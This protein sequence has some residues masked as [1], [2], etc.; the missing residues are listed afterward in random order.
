MSTVIVLGLGPG[1]RGTLSV[2]AV[3]RLSRADI[4]VVDASVATASWQSV[5]S[6]KAR[7]EL[8]AQDDDER[9]RAAVIEHA[10]A[11]RV[12]VR[13][14]G[15][16]GWTSSAA[17]R[18]IRGARR[19]G[20]A[21]DVVP[22]IAES[23]A[24]C[25]PWLSSHP[26]FGRRIV[27]TRMRD[28]ASDTAR[29]L[30]DRG[31]EPWVVPTIELRPSPEPERFDGALR[32]LR[33]YQL[34]AFT[35][36]NGVEQTFERLRSMGKDA[37]ELGACAVAA[38]GTATARSLRERGIDADIIAKEFRGEELAKAILERI[39]ELSGRRVLI[40]RAA[41][42]REVLPEMLREA[43]CVVDV[44]P[45][46]ETVAPGPELVAPFR[47]AIA[48]GRVDA[49]LLTSS[50]TVKN[51][52]AMLGQ[53]YAEL[54]SMTVLA[55]IGPITSQTARELGLSIGVEAEQ[56]TIAGLIAALE[57]SFRA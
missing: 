11:G 37:R 13:A 47:E 36:A 41:E 8:V 26:L 49:V 23:A 28:Q 45:A 9:A 27:V 22:G 40:P 57:S 12:V 2:D 43:G 3:D 38:I 54:L 24:A 39:R 35:S 44:V 6:A 14:R 16:D 10:A 21:V 25:E 52:C 50:S 20:L 1:H 33:S 19:A 34:V 32:S 18:D 46:Y 48:H 4:V 31:A 56:F 42:A 5:L 15:G 51:L 55:S 17:L 29:S 7:V 53:D 30:S